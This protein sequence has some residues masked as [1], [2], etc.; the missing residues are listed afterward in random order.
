MNVAELAHWRYRVRAI[1]SEI[2]RL[3]GE[4]SKFIEWAADYCISKAYEV[5]D[6]A[7]IREIRYTPNQWDKAADEQQVYIEVNQY[8]LEEAKYHVELGDL[9]QVIDGMAYCD[10]CGRY[11][12][13]R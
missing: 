9:E 12:E 13:K 8:L 11:M 3:K 5:T 6:K 10:R 2:D 4:Q 1:Y 7:R